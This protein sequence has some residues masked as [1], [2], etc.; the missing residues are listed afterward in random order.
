MYGGAVKNIVIWGYCFEGL[1]LSEMIYSDNRYCFWG[2]VD[3]NPNM[4]GLYSYGQPIR[5]M[6]LL[7]ELD[8]QIDNLSVIIASNDYIDIIKLFEKTKIN[9]EGVYIKR[10]LVEYSSLARFNSLDLSQKVV[11]FAG[12]IT[13]DININKKEVYGLSINKWDEKHIFHDITE[14]YPLPNNCIDSYI[15]ENVFEFIDEQLYEKIL[16]EIYR[17][18]K[19]G[20]R[21][22]IS[23]P[24]YNSPFMKRRVLTNKIGEIV[25]DGREDAFMSLGENGIIGGT[26]FFSTVENLKFILEKSMF[27]KFDWLRY[28]LKDGTQIRKPIDMNNGYLWRNDKKYELEDYNIVVDCIK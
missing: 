2:F 19:V 21:L 13:D 6:K 3:N 1:Y 18:L 9:I 7:K 25:F 20:G 23:M 22:R 24:D 26:L 16:N 15:S 12:D 4:Q 10:R 8:D 5:N 28:Y 11:L 17:I 27:C 14:E